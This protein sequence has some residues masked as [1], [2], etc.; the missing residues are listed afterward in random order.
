MKQLRSFNSQIRAF[1]SCA[2]SNQ[3]RFLPVH[4][5]IKE[6]NLKHLWVNLSSFFTHVTA[7]A[8]ASTLKKQL[9]DFGP[10]LVEERTSGGRF[11]RLKK[12]TDKLIENLIEFKFEK[13]TCTNY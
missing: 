4:F 12:L 10:F 13:D 3:N 7:M 2:I 9:A 6:H 1:S 11:N 8:C 5:P